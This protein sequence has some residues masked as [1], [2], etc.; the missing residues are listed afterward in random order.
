MVLY[1]NRAIWHSTDFAITL[2]VPI[3]VLISAVTAKLQQSVKFNEEIKVNE[4]Q[5]TTDVISD[6]GKD[7]FDKAENLE[8]ETIDY[9]IMIL[10]IRPEISESVEFLLTYYARENKGKQYVE[11]MFVKSFKLAHPSWIIKKVV[12]E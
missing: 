8:N 6:L 1:M 4:Q 2:W 5:K 9:K 11:E 7:N 12:V 10:H 3:K